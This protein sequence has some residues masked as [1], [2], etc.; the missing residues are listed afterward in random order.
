MTEKH[1]TRIWHQAITGAIFNG[2]GYGWNKTVM[3]T[4]AS[5]IAGDTLR[6]RFSNRN[7]AKPY[8]IGAMNMIVN[9]NVYPITRAGQHQFQIPTG[10]ECYSDVCPIAV[11]AGSE[12][13]FRLY[14]TGP[15]LDSNS[16][17]EEAKV[18]SGNHTAVSTTRDKFRKPFLAA[19]LGS[20]NP[21]PAIEAIEVATEA[22]VK[23]VVAFGDS[24]TALSRWTKP[25]AAR[26][27]NRFHGEYILLN[28]GISGNCLLFETSGVT[29]SMFGKMGSVR[30]ERDVLTVP[31]LSV[32]ILGLGV[33][34][35]SYLNK[36]TADQINLENYQK[37]ITS[38]VQA[39]KKRGVRVVMQTV[40]PRLGVARS[41][42][43]Y[44]REM[45][46]LRLAL[47]DWIRNAGIFDYLFDAE[48]VVRE[49]RPDG[50]YFKEGLHQ[51][52]HLHPNIEGGKLLAEA[53]DLEMLT[54]EQHEEI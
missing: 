9:G 16:I 44:T 10:G 35:V 1:W 22:P 48:A 27:E 36:K 12:L 37:E 54:G 52:D 29:A 28:S 26:L 45:E 51:G 15:I 24:I 31:D 7:G 13:E 3:F 17:E 43:K 40:T 20:Y 49:E 11:N 5:P 34:D 41:M 33:N 53:F 19:R 23:A 8:E 4:V 6:I 39:L 42:G 46:V 50:F 32:V 21:I 18:L 30:F 38:I 2:K 47:N 25:L 14:Y